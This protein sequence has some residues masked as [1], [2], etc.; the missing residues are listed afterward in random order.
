MNIWFIRHYNMIDS[1]PHLWGKE[2]VSRGHQATLF[3]SSY[4]IHTLKE[5][6]LKPLEIYKIEVID[7]VRFIWLRGIPYKKNDWRRSLD[8]IVF[9]IMSIIVGLFL[10]DK[11]DV[12][13]GT[14]VHPFAPVAAFILSIVKKCRYNYELNDVWPQVLV[15]EG[16]KSE[17]SLTIRFLRWLERFL[18]TRSNKVQSILPHVD[19]YLEDIGIS[20]NKFI[21]VPNPVTVKGGE[22]II[23]PFKGT[24]DGIFRVMLITTF[25]P[26]PID[27]SVVLK[28]AQLLQN[29]KE[30][31]IRI[32]FVGDGRARQD[33]EAMRNK[34]G[35]KNVDFTG[36][37]EPC[38]LYKV[39]NKAS[40]F[41]VTAKPYRIHRYGIAFNKLYT[42]MMGKRPIIFTSYD[43]NNPIEISKGG[44]TIKDG[45][46]IGLSEAIVKLKSLPEEDMNQMGMNNYNYV[47]MVHNIVT[48]TDALL[49]A[50][51][52]DPNCG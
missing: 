7:N 42:S 22:E 15:E 43:S 12:I 41:L 17:N 34:M 18:I 49:K 35:L 10:K 39:M 46:P 14:V 28:A 20:R 30:E 4:N 48:S 45:D 21:W 27:Y 25:P 31:D 40:A 50:L 2:L 6:H 37:V 8:T 29:S 47:V 9:T 23:E 5:E 33:V 24:V 11:P 36:W 32:V 26:N 16:I 44:I 1:R 51:E 3:A 19:D 52:K 38:D 13:I